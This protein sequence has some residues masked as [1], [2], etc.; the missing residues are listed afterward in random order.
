MLKHRREWH[1]IKACSNRQASPQSEQSG[2][3]QVYPGQ[4]ES[5]LG[6]ARAEWGCGCSGQS[7]MSWPLSQLVLEQSRDLQRGTSLQQLPMAQLIARLLRT[8]SQPP[9]HTPERLQIPRLVQSGNVPTRTA[10]VLSLLP[11]KHFRGVWSISTRLKCYI[12]YLYAYV[13]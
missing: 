12:L 5:S 13:V 8:H 7:V 10:L 3:P 1:D 4:W 2:S 11:G 6:V 9:N